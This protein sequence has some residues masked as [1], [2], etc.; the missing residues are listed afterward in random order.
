MPTSHPKDRFDTLPRQLDR[1]GAHRAPARKGRGWIGFWWALAATVVLIALGVVWLSVLNNRLSFDLSGLPAASATPSATASPAK[2]ATPSATPSA[3]PTVAP[4]VDPSLT[5]T[6]LNGTLTTGVARGV[7]ERLTA[8]GWTVG[9]LSDASTSDVTKTVVYYAD[10]KLEGAARG[11]AE[12]VPGS[13]ILLSQDFADTRVP[14]TVV[15]GSDYVP[16]TG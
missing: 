1:V 6:V 13:T 11:V 9:K 4:T 8:A 15:I 7:G 2:S 16:P 14:L 3:V 5:V 12:S 10:A